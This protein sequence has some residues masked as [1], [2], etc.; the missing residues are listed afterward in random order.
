M[1]NT[2]VTTSLRLVQA[3]FFADKIKI[4]VDIGFWFC[5]TPII[6]DESITFEKEFTMFDDL[7][8]EEVYGTDHYFD[9]SW[10]DYCDE[11]DEMYG[12]AEDNL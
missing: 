8:C 5:Y 2:L 11:M 1:T 9:E 10:S 3:T 12:T 4:S 6:S 7:Q